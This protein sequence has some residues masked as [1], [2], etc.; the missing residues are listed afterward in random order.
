[1]NRYADGWNQGNREKEARRRLLA[2]AE[3]EPE[4]EIT[5][6]KNPLRKAEPI[7]IKDTRPP[8]RGF[9]RSQLIA[10]SREKKF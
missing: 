7:A 5:I 9:S 3:P 10:D 2:P 8:K 6:R 4:I 1:M